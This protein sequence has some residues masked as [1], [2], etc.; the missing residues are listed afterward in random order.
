MKIYSLQ[1]R[2]LDVNTLT[3]KTFYDENIPPYAIL[4]HTW[5]Y[6]A[7]NEEISFSEFLKIRAE[8]AVIPQDGF[9]RSSDETKPDRLWRVGGYKKIVDFCAFVKK[10]K[11]F[12]IARLETRIPSAL[13]RDYTD[14]HPE[15]ESLQWVWIDTCCI[16]SSSSSEVSEAINSFWSWYSNAVECYIYLSDYASYQTFTDSRWFKRGWTLQELLASKT[17]IFCSSDWKVLGYIRSRQ[18]ITEPE[19]YDGKDLTAKICDKTKI[20]ER[21]ISG[22]KSLQLASIAERLSWAADRQTSR[23]EDRFYCL[24]GL[25][26]IHMSPLYGEGRR[27]FFRLQEEIIRTSGDL[28]IFH[29]KYLTENPSD[30]VDQEKAPAGMLAPHPGCFKRSSGFEPERATPGYH[31]SC[32]SVGVKLHVQSQVVRTRPDGS[33]GKSIL[34]LATIGGWPMEPPNSQYWKD[35]S[36]LAVIECRHD[37]QTSYYRSRC[38]NVVEAGKIH[39]SLPSS[40]KVEE[41]AQ[42]AKIYVENEC[43]A[44]EQR[45]RCEMCYQNDQWFARLVSQ[46]VFS[47]QQQGRDQQVF[48]NR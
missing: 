3:Y 36:V 48:V 40:W 5:S 33:I 1:M 14:H 16:D 31:S 19:K 35:S 23:V 24:L 26:D 11:I 28:S 25:L 21:Y 4:S 43:S 39:L 17:R 13:W 8:E 7:G 9:D 27:A 34:Y 32:K 30:E 45:E 37:P 44:L 18:S 41:R 22:K 47:Q 38:N 15:L 20:L 6:E 42:E 29:W 12:N 46:V 2:L 10:R